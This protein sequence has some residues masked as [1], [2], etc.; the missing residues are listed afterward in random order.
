MPSDY[1]GPVETEKESEIIREKKSSNSRLEFKP[2]TKG[3]GFHP[4][5]EV[6]TRK[7]TYTQG[8]PR[9]LSTIPSPEENFSKVVPTAPELPSMKPIAQMPQISR[10]MVFQNPKNSV[11]AGHQPAKSISTTPLTEVAKSP[12][13]LKILSQR[14]FAY[15]LD[16]ALNISL[17]TGGLSLALVKFQLNAKHLFGVDTVVY[18]VI[19][20]LFFNWILLL[21]QEVVFGTTL[22]KRL[23]GLTLKHSNGTELRASS[24]AAV[25]LR[26]FF[27]I[28]SVL[29]FG[30]GIL[31]AV[32]DKKLRCWHDLV[33]DVYPQR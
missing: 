16:S 10:P 12:G 20:L 15:L 13:R 4:F 8:Q 25:F 22:C 14:V 33:S 7:T 21:A 5:G 3:L 30:L 19:F 31:W 6:T 18:T 1:D 29:F 32:F 26:A 11:L 27:F 28:P 2:L 9:P 23:F 24:A 17:C